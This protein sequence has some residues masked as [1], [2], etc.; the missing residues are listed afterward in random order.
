MTALFIGHA[1]IDITFLA[2]HIPT[3][4]EK[5]VAENYAV[6][7]GGNAVSA[8]FCAAKLGAASTLICNLAPDH[9]GRLFTTMADDYGLALL[10]VEV[11][12]SSPSFI[13]P[14]DQKRAILRCR[15]AGYEDTIPNH[16]LEDVKILHVDGHIP[17][18]SLF[19]AEK[20]RERGIITSLDG[21]GLRPGFDKLIKQID[22]AIVAERLAEQMNLNHHQ[23]L[24]YLRDN[25]VKVGGITRGSKGLL[26]F[27]NSSELKEL[28]AIPLPAE[29][30]VD[31]NGAGDIFHGAYVYSYHQNPQKPW[32]E[33]FK[34]ARAAATFAVQNLGNHA[35]CPTLEQLKPYLK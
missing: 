15:D 26:W 8:A 31:T 10:P 27:E 7:F 34:F 18:A 17:H 11:A 35:S 19:Y 13:M 5:A 6:S 25:G 32:E 23:M 3:G 24:D 14:K 1:Y 29:Q 22:V 9:L 33:H 30:V 21:G 16:S 28:P 12:R 2:D 4:D 20:C